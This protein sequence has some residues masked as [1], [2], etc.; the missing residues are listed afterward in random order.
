MP[1]IPPFI[2]WSQVQYGELGERCAHALEGL[3]DG[4]LHL[5][6]AAWIARAVRRC[7]CEETAPAVSGSGRGQGHHTQTPSGRRQVLWCKKMHL[8][9]SANS[10]QIVSTL[11]WLRIPI[12]APT[13]PQELGLS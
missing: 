8:P 7:L 3:A 9:S 4:A 2:Y 6:L 1:L 13:K 11:L 5:A 12:C 10:G